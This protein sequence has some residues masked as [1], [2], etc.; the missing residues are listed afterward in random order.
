M[1]A[2]NWFWRNA[3]F[4]LPG[5]RKASRESKASLRRYSHAEPWNWLLPDLV[6]TFTTPPRTEPNSAESA[7]ETTL[8]S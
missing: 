4:L 8:N 3:G 6:T 7:W 2:P 5:K 1:E